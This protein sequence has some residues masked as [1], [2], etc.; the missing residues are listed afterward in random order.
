MSELPVRGEAVRALALPLPPAR[1]ALVRGGRLLKR[2]RFVAVFA[3]ELAVCAATVRVGPAAQRFWAVAE[4]GGRLTAHT[5][6]AGRGGPE[7]APGRLAIDAR[8]HGVRAELSLDEAAGPEPVELVAPSG[9]RAYAWT[10]KQA[11][12]AARG[13]VEVGGRRVEVDGAAAIDVSAGYHHYRT[14]W[15]WSTGAGRTGDGRAVAWNLVEGVNDDPHVSERTVWV[16]GA[17]REVGPV[18][19]ARDLSSIRFTSGEELRLADRWATR[20]HVTNLL[21]VKSHHVMPFGAFEGELPGGLRLAEARG[22][23]ERHVAR[24]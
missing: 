8:G 7:L 1:M 14:A 13:W 20:D 15:R 19:F 2:W 17:A 4:P 18:A 5:A 12:V 3:P 24:W 16:D 21:V 6:M 22:A 11:G 10:R 9:A 23:M